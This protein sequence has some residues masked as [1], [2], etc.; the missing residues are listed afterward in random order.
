M[1]P[2]FGIRNTYV[3]G[4]S[5]VLLWRRT[6]L[7][8]STVCLCVAWCT[9]SCATTAQLAPGEQSREEMGYVCSA[10]YK[11]PDTL[12][13]YKRYPVSIG[14]CVPVKYYNTHVRGCYIDKD[15]LPAEECLG[16][17]RDWAGK[18]VKTYRTEEE[19]SRTPKESTP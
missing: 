14:R 4:D 9:A 2:L 5:R 18:C 13:C 10:E 7:I 15:C 12:R 8:T 17:T 1:A 11:C 16:R 3:L 19:K 6:C